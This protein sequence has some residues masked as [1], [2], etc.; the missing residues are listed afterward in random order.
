MSEHSSTDSTAGSCGASGRIVFGGG[1]TRA[2]SSCHLRRCM[3]SW[4]WSTCFR[5]FL[6]SLRALVR[7]SLR[8]SCMPEIG[9]YS[10]S[11][12]RRS[13]R[14]RTSSD[15]T[16][17]AATLTLVS[18]G[19]DSAHHDCRI[20]SGAGSQSHR[21]AWRSKQELHVYAGGWMPRHVLPTLDRGR[22]MSLDPF[23]GHSD[24][25]HLE[26]TLGQEACAPNYCNYE[27]SFA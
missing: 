14:E 1:G 5:S 6:L 10:L 25:T 27:G 26:L 3:K 22:S 24:G 12:G 18:F 15:P 9:T 7:G 4:A 23:I 21:F 19:A 17:N 2:G 20:T 11:G 16:G 13:A 8:E